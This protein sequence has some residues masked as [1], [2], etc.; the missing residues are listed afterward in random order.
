[1][2]SPAQ[3]KQLGIAASAAVKH[4]RMVKALS[5]ETMPPDLRTASASAQNEFWRHQQVALVTQRVC[6]FKEMT[7]AEYNPVMQHFEA[8]AGPFWKG[9]AVKRTV[10]VI[11]GADCDRAPGCEYVRDMRHWMSKAGLH[12]SY[13][14]PIMKRWQATEIRAL[15]TWQLKELHDTVVNR[16]RAKLGLGDAAN[17]NKKQRAERKAQSAEPQKAEPQSLTASAPAKARE[18]ILKP[19]SPRPANYVPNPEIEPF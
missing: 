3:L 6:S 5:A 4:Q 11:D 13:C 8:L 9:R 15:R 1:M 17:R 18:Y 16:C 2:M 12:E 10:K 14:L 7:Q 19:R